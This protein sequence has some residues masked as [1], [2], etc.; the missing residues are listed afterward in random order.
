MTIE[1]RPITK[2]EIEML[3][4]WLKPQNAGLWGQTYKTKPT[5]VD[6]VF[7]DGGSLITLD[8]ANSRPDFYIMLAPSEITCWEDALNFIADNEEFIYEPIEIEFGNVDDEDYDENEHPDG[9]L[10]LNIGSGYT[11]GHYDN[12]TN[13]AKGGE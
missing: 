8:P 10:A 13:T 12:F 11:A 9:C 3:K 4:P 1:T 6:T 7:G 5:L 2:E